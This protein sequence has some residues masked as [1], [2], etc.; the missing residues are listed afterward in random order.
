M[1][2]IAKGLLIAILLHGTYNTASTLIG[3]LATGLGGVALTFG[4][5]LVFHVAAFV[6]LFL[7]LRRYRIAYA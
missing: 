1:A 4:F 6:Y 7:K 2:I 5:I 3:G